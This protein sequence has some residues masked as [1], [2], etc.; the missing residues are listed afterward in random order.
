MKV[1][2]KVNPGQRVMHGEVYEEGDEFE[3]ERKVA[4]ALIKS[5]AC[6]SL[7]DAE[8]SKAGSEDAKNSKTAKAKS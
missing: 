5:G 3:C 2:V 8:P 7:K 4:D 6:A 1:T